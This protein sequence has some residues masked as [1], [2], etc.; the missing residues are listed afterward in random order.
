[1]TAAQKESKEFIIPPVPHTSLLLCNI[2]NIDHRIEVIHTMRQKMKSLETLQHSPM[3]MDC[4]KDPFL[5]TAAFSPTGPS[6]RW[7]S[8]KR[9]SEDCKTRNQRESMFSIKFSLLCW[10]VEFCC[11]VFVLSF[12]HS[13]LTCLFQGI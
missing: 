4:G 1:M 6:F 10:V 7:S 5:S 2:I 8:N 12:V 3:V 9:G 11:V 13:C